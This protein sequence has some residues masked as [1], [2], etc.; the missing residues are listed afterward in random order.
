M[1]LTMCC[2][3]MG[4]ENV[5]PKLINKYHVIK[6]LQTGYTFYQKNKI[7]LHHQINSSSQHMKR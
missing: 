3:K 7:E 5:V 6:K 1:N 2:N 4:I